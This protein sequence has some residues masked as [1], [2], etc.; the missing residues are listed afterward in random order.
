[1][2]IINFCFSMNSVK[3]KQSYGK[4]GFAN[5][6]LFCSTILQVFQHC[7]HTV[8]AGIANKPTSRGGIGRGVSREGGIG[9]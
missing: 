6:K 2:P 9:G 8:V 7:S 4:V 5:I 1:M 3:A